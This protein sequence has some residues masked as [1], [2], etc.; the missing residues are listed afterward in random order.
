MNRTR[1]ILL[2][3]PRSNPSHE[4]LKVLNSRCAVF[5]NLEISG[6]NRVKLYVLMRTLWFLLTNILL[7]TRRNLGRTRL[8]GRRMVGVKSIGKEGDN[9]MHF[10]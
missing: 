3:P 7:H 5:H 8:Y 2:W 1:N 9:G 10:F 4:F 6:Q